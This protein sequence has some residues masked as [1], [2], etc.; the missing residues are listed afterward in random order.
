MF[1]TRD[2]VQK[3]IPALAGGSFDCS[4]ILL[5]LQVDALNGIRDTLNAGVVVV[6]ERKTFYGARE[7]GVRGPCGTLLAFAAMEGEGPAN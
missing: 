7:I 5:C 6:P 3:D 1:G 4:G 2:G